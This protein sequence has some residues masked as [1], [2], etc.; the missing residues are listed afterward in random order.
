[1]TGTHTDV[2]FVKMNYIKKLG[3]MGRSSADQRDHAL[4]LTHL[5]KLFA[6]FRHPTRK[7]T[8]E[9]QEYKLY[10]MIP[11][12]VK[13]FGEVPASEMTEKFGDV[14]QFC[15]HL[16]KLMVTEIRRRAS[17]QSTEA[18]SCAIVTFLEM[19]S[20]ETTGNGWM[21]LTALN[22]LSCGNQA[23]I[24]CMTAASLPS[25]LVKCLY[26]FFDLPEIEDPDKCN[27]NSEFT[28]EERR[29]LLQKI[30]VQILVHLCKHTSP[31][32]EL[33][34]KDDL[35]LL[36][37]AITSWCPPHNAIWRKCAAEILMTLSRH[38]LTPTVVR[39]IHGKV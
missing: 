20:S 15:S 12:F 30:W 32:E 7:A 28:A 10:N 5:R 6:E 1:M 3:T 25:T 36:F 16:S 29:A 4:G 33:A 14:L 37:S 21:L 26:L 19:D 35:S 23:L 31:A 2:L 24:D 17:N 27:P 8:Q 18:A 34:R 39:Y 13:V 38:G 11:L 22:L 9:E